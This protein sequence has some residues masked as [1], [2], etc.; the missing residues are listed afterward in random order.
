MMSDAAR[1]QHEIKLP[2]VR[3]I[4]H[5]GARLTQPPFCKFIR[6]SSHET[7]SPVRIATATSVPVKRRDTDRK[8]S[9]LGVCM[10]V[11]L[12]LPKF[13]ESHHRERL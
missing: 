12:L 6:K 5:E 3:Q 4:V 1:H 11:V 2:H 8:I 9:S 7:F 10:N 13:A